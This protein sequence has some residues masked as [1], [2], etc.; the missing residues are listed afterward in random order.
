MSLLSL[1]VSQKQASVDIAA[2]PLEKGDF[3]VLLSVVRGLRCGGILRGR[4]A[5]EHPD[6]GCNKL[7][8]YRF[9]SPRDPFHARM[10]LNNVGSLKSC[11][12]FYGYSSRQSR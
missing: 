3:S 10:W 1:L 6:L 2:Q 4:P 9:N 8:L 7:Y 12:S 11:T 5:G